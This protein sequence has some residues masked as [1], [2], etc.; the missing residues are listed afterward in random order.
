MH[1][2][3]IRDVENLSGIK[4]HTLRM[5]EQRYGLCLCKRKESLHRYYDNEDLKHILRIAYLYHNGYKISRIAQ[6]SQEEIIQQASRIFESDEYEVM[7]NQLVEAGMDYNQE[8]FENAFHSALR[9]MGLER[10][11]EKLVYPFMDKIGL[12]WMTGHV[13]PAQEHFCSYLVQKAVIAAI[14][15]LPTVHTGNSRFL[16]F[17]PPGEDHELPLLFI[18]YIIKKKGYNNI[19]LGK[20]IS[21]DII[22]E[23][24]SCQPVT[25]LY[26]HLIT[27]FTNCHPEQYLGKLSAAFADKRIIASGPALKDIENIPGNVDILRSFHEAMAFEFA[28]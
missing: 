4:A 24:C 16:L 13:L 2:F 19:L 14:N 1:H 15:A 11:M 12:L 8:Q 26:F 3:T 17:T 23:Y 5:W 20:N 27:N 18:Q 21:I 9:T 22:K 6:F 7:I 25:H 10:T 28:G